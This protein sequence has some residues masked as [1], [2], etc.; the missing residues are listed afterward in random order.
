MTMKSDI[1]FINKCDEGT[2]IYLICKIS[3]S[4]K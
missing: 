3:K 4:G 2:K 1:D